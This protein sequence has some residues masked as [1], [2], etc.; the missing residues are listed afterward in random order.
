MKA[1]SDLPLKRFAAA[2]AVALAIPLT[3]AAFS[4]QKGMLHGACDGMGAKAGYGHHGMGGDGIPRQLRRLDLSEAQRD[5]IFDIM[6]AQAPTLRDT[7]KAM[8]KAQND[9]R[10]LTAAPDFSEAKAKQLA[11]A[12]AA[13]MGEMALNRAKTERQ[14]Y[15]VLTPEQRQQ[16]ADIKPSGD[17]PRQRGDGPRGP[18]GDGMRPMRGA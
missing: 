15:E 3:A 7:A 4:G 14:V 13:A 10:E 18:A 8:H 12:A 11:N 5:R 16:L 6:H 17:R 9:L 2:A 1:I